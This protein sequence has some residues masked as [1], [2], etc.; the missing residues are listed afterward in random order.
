V[1]ALATSTA[2]RLEA[3]GHDLLT[4][5]VA[6]LRADCDEL[7]VLVRDAE[8]QLSAASSELERARGELQPETFETVTAQIRGARSRNGTVGRRLLRM[9][10][11]ASPV[12][13]TDRA[14]LA[15]L[16]SEK[17]ACADLIRAER[18][19]AAAL[20]TAADWQS[21]SFGSSTFPCAGRQCGRIRPHWNDYKRDRHLDAAAYERAYAARMVDG[22]AGLRALLT[23]CGMGAFTTVVAFLRDAGRLEGPIVVGRGLYHE[24]RLLLERALSGS[25]HTVDERDTGALLRAIGALRPSAVFLDSLSNTTWMPVPDLPAV[26]ERLRGGTTYL[27]ID[28]TGLSVSFQPFAIA[29]DG[30]PLIVFE[31]LLKY[32]Q[33]GLDRVNAGVI[34][35]RGEDGDAL[36][37]YREHLGTNISDLAA[38]AL[39]TPLRWVLERRLARIG[40][41]CTLLAGRLACRVGRLAEIVYPGLPGHPSHRVAR[42]LAF[43][44]GCLSIVLRDDDRELGRARALIE[45]AVAKGGQRG[46]ALTAGASFGFD[47]TRI[48]LTAANAECGEPFL[49]VSAGTEHTLELE[50][51]ADVLEAAVRRA[52][53]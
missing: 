51:L 34:V 45:A 26:I 16:A 7:L 21:P 15:E 6:D 52:A 24:T 37:D 2:A 13:P 5:A 14:A 12:R 19:L 46:V 28:N 3:S 18:T 31:S 35:A 50:A 25:I 30:L 48:Y 49:R 23:S 10:Q 53:A 42:R 29:G 47:T 38:C 36:A 39:P 44:G 11:L 1:C 41:N 17:A 40:R 9:R 22:S 4:E 43:R 27:V 20:T 32:A 33:L 8:S